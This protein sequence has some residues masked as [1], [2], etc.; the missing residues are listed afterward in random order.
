MSSLVDVAVEIVRW[1]AL[2]LI[3]VGGLVGAVI[4]ELF[5]SSGEQPRLP[6]GQMQPPNA[7][8]VPTS[9]RPP[10]PPPRD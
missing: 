6:R 4:M 2:A 10:K 7:P 1:V 3:I 9:D 5:L 8:P